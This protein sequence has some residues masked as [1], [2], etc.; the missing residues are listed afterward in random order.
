[1][2]TLDATSKS[3]E[4]D[5]AGAVNSTELD[6]SVDYAVFEGI[7]LADFANQAGVTSG[8]TAVTMVT[9][10]VGV[11]RKLIKTITVTN[12]DD[13]VATVT[14]QLNDGTVRL[15]YKAAAVPVGGGVRYANG[16]WKTHAASGA[17]L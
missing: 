15:L 11:Q 16:I 10:P 6:W 8:A 17:E 14:V 13:A 9:A 5:L 12:T 4:V 7:Q 2:I 1:M 3:L